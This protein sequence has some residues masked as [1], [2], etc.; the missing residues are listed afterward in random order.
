MA[1]KGEKSNGSHYDAMFG[2]Y[3]DKEA[4]GK[5]KKSKLKSIRKLSRGK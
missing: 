5:K 2:H 4:G 3:L 1:H